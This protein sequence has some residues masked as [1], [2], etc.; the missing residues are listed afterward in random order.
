MPATIKE[1]V[2]DKKTVLLSPLC[3]LQRED[4]M[5]PDGVLLIAYRQPDD[6]YAAMGI[7]PFRCLLDK[8]KGTVKNESDGDHVLVVSRVGHP[9]DLTIS[10][11]V[12]AKGSDVIKRHAAVRLVDYMYSPMAGVD[13]NT[14]KKARAGDKEE[15]EKFLR[16][17]EDLRADFLKERLSSLID[18]NQEFFLSLVSW[19]K[20]A[21]APDIIRISAISSGQELTEIREFGKSPGAPDS[22]RPQSFDFGG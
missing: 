19:T 2:F 22:D 16:Q 18:A 17:V 4:K 10:F 5:L 11:N 20:N 7:D 8:E 1:V 15:M 14:A 6:D 13:Q 12:Y 3:V 21:F 9:L